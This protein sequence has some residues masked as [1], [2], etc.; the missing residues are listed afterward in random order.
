MGDALRGRQHRLG[1]PDALDQ[2]DL[3]HRYKPRLSDENKLIADWLVALTNAKKTRGFGPCF[4]QLHIGLAWAANGPRTMPNGS[5]WTHKRVYRGSGRNMPRQALGHSYRHGPDYV[6]ARLQIWA[7]TAG[8]R[9]IYI[10]PARPQQN[11]CV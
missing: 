3:A 8:I 9:S 5:K 11:A 2:R 4:L 1:L 10:Q 7:E 6:R